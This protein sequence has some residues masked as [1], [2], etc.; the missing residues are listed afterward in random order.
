MN[1]EERKILLNRLEL[2][3]VVLLTLFGFLLVVLWIIIWILAVLGA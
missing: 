2:A 1:Q 3:R